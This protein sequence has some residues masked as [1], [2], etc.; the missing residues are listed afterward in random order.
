MSKVLIK[1]F[2]LLGL[3]QISLGKAQENKGIQG[4][5][6]RWSVGVGYSP[7][8]CWTGDDLNKYNGGIPI[9]PTAHFYWL[10][11]FRVKVSY[12][13]TPKYEAEFGS[14]YLWANLPNRG[15]SNMRIPTEPYESGW[16]RISS[17]WKI[18]CVPISFGI[19]ERSPVGKDW[20]LRSFQIGIIFSKGLVTATSGQYDS[21]T[22]EERIRADYA[23]SCGRGL[24]C[25]I[26]IGH[27]RSISKRF[28]WDIS[29]MLRVGFSEEYKYSAPS[30]VIWRGP[31]TLS[32]CGLYVNIG[33]NYVR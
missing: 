8:I 23:T 10:N 9:D 12:Q 19:K 16:Y 5:W 31:I 1:G 2:I 29:L 28:H 22:G 26:A 14:G 24:N 21:E 7:G 30:D 25:S 33:I 17:D 15:I 11:S 4:F 3:L 32:F 6:D 13:I 20:A 18:W 27:E